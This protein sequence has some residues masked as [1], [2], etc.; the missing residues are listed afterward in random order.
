MIDPKT[1]DLQPHEYRRLEDPAPTIVTMSATRRVIC[2]VF[3]AVL[4]YAGG[5]S[6]WHQA[7]HLT[8]RMW[9]LA[10]I[11]ALTWVALG[12][13]LASTALWP[14]GPQTRV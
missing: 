7:T 9:P 6:L 11:A 1:I 2:A 3:G 12:L 13:L 5:V 8:E 10:F 4:L 14:N